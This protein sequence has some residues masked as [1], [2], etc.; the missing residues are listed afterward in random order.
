DKL[1]A[2]PRIEVEPPTVSV[3]VSVSTSPN[4][5]REGEYLTSRKLEEF[6]IDAVRK[7]VSLKYEATEDPKVFIL[8]ARG[9]LQVAVVFEEIRRQ[10]YELMIARPEVIIKE[11][12]GQTLEP[13]E[14]LVLDVP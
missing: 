4:S 9:E 8:K 12:N 5:G 2:L 1:E 14:R 3:R 7:N 13:F 6:L 10:G 11:E